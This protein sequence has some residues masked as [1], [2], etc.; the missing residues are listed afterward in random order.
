MCTSMSTR[1]HAFPKV[2]QKDTFTMTVLFNHTTIDN[3]GN[4]PGNAKY[5]TLNKIVKMFSDQ[6]V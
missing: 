2:L 5:F 1:V 6:K 3:D 4:V